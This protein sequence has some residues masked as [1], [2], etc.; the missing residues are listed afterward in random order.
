MPYSSALS[1]KV[2]SVLRAHLLRDDGQEDVCFAVYHPSQ[3]RDRLTAVLH[4]PVLP[5]NGERAV[6][7]NAS[8]TDGYFLR[9]ASEAAA[10]GGGI[11]LL[12]SHPLGSGWQEMSPDDVNAERGHAQQA[13]GLTGLPLFGL[14]LAGDGTWSC[15]AWRRAGRNDYPRSDGESV[16]VVGTAFKVSHNPA[17]RPRRNFGE[18]HIRTLSAWGERVQGDLSR[19]RVGVVGLGSVGAIVAEALARTG[20]GELVLIDY[21]SVKWKNLDRVLHATRLDALILRRK[22]D[23][24]AA[25]VR[26]LAAEPIS[27]EVVDAGVTEEDGYRRALDC[28]VLF[29]CVDANWPRCVLNVMAYAHL[30]PVVDGGIR[31]V[32]GEH[33]MVGAHWRTQV[34]APGRKCMECSQAYD[35]GLVDCERSGLAED[36]KYIEGLPKGHDLLAGENVFAFSAACASLELLQTILMVAAP[37]RVSDIGIQTY[38]LVRGE[39][40]KDEGDCDGGCA[41][42]GPWQ[43]LGDNLRVTLVGEDLRAERERG[44]REQVQKR[45]AVRVALVAIDAIE[46]VHS[47]VEHFVQ[48]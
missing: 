33:G 12:H 14:T 11:A 45:L 1:S 38:Q 13:L 40:S 30:I 36:P 19:L 18:S 5:L 35:P 16:R 21:D 25:A 28:D 27:V 22:G 26:R 3:G 9:A 32:T 7:G 17:M 37:G 41:Y 43:S 6:H 42:S 2:D 20:I 24:V 15:R 44:L 10:V 8:F 46:R 39:V 31:V 23:V 29:S 47:V 48:R 34:A 4:H